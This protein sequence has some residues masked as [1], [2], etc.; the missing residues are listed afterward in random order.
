[1]KFDVNT[2]THTHTI[3]TNIPFKGGGTKK[4]FLMEMMS[5]SIPR[6]FLLHSFGSK[7]IAVNKD[8]SWNRLLVLF[9]HS[10]APL[11]NR[12]L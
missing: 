8:N 5:L 1:M 11:G 3:H 2:H 4:I 7:A 6:A 12:I 9:T 10:S